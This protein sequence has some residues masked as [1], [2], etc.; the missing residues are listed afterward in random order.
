MR[1][2]EEEEEEAEAAEKQA[3]KSKL[4]KSI[5]T[6]AEKP[7]SKGGEAQ[8]VDLWGLCGAHHMWHVATFSFSF[9]F[10]KF[11]LHSGQ[12]VGRSFSSAQLSSARGSFSSACSSFS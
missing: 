3:E 4:A 8:G 2:A 5:D 10:F 12:E 11:F 7:A 6:G 1:E 9:Y